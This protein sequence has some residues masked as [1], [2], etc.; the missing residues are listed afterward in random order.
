MRKSVKVGLV[1]IG[2]FL[3]GIL[4]AG[5][6]FLINLFSNN[7]IYG[8]GNSL[9]LINPVVETENLKLTFLEAG[10]ITKPNE[11][12]LTSINV[13]N[14]DSFFIID[15]EIENK[16]NIN[17]R[18]DKIILEGISS[19]GI[20]DSKNINIT[21]DSGPKISGELVKK[22]HLLQ[23][24]D[25][26]EPNEK[27]R[28]AVYV[29]LG[30]SIEKD[31]IEEF[32]FVYG[33]SEENKVIGKLT[34]E[35]FSDKNLLE[36]DTLRNTESEDIELGILTKGS[37]N[38]INTK[39]VKL[40]GLEIDLLESVYFEEVPSEFK[41]DYLHLSSL[42]DIGNVLLVKAKIKNASSEDRYIGDFLLSNSEKDVFESIRTVESDNFS[43]GVIPKD[44]ISKY[45]YL[46]YRVNEEYSKPLKAGEEITGNILFYSDQIK[47]GSE[48]YL[49]V[50]G[51]NDVSNQVILFIK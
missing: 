45:D 34:S 7:T 35:S 33:D 39:S 11:D 17:K 1:V 47:S 4:A 10:L 18:L 25:Y 31:T 29:G 43:I 20:F 41:D 19:N 8:K 28:G 22:Y 44:L 51:L 32:T 38:E 50:K 6:F 24:G 49:R 5:I 40:E 13:I 26:L 37:K 27:A 16:S 15:L 9:E 21:G 30:N 46:N 23:T 42:S 3:L 2:L 36:L 14:D 12:F 48:Y